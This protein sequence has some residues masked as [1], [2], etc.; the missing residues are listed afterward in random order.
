MV[1][2]LPGRIRTLG[3]RTLLILDL[4]SCRDLRAG[5]ACWGTG[6]K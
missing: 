4:V 2:T 6:L 5:G 1:G 3:I